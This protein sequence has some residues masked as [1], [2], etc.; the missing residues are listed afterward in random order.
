MNVG[1]ICD[2]LAAYA[3]PV[4][5]EEWDAVGLLVGDRSRPL[6]RLM[7]CLTITPAS[8]AE[9][10]ERQADLIVSHHPLPFR[11]L[12]RITTE[13]TAGRLLW[14]LIG[15]QIAVYSPHTAFDSCQGGINQRL[16]ERCGLQEVQ[17][18]VPNRDWPQVGGG[19]YGVVMPEERLGD[20]VDRVK[21]ALGL[22]T[23][24]GVGRPDQAVRRVAVACGSAGSLMEPA[25][26]AGCDLLVTGETS[27]HSCLEAEAQGIGLLLVGHYASERFAIEELARD[28]AR[29]YTSLEI[30]ASQSE[31]D[32]IH[33]W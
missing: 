12:P 24:R 10:M 5:A 22:T 3:P 6:Q 15:R 28:L 18:L 8:A 30:W 13:V 27:F 7:T 4:L 33:G 29:E 31:S 9:A 1:T 20:F 32:P 26:L 17:P 14:Q 23:V 19:R 16:A 11:P 25:L 2:Y 21:S